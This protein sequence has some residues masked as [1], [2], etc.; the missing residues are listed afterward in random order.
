MSYLKQ[1]VVSL[2]DLTSLNND[3]TRTEIDVLISKSLNALGAVVAI[4]IY[5]EFISYAKAKIKNKGDNI[6]LA[7]VVNFPDAKEDLV[8]CI[9]LTEKALSGG[10]DEIDVVIPYHDYL[11]TG[12]S[13][14]A[15]ML[16]REL[17][18]LCVNKTL[19]VIIESGELKDASLIE[20]ASFDA[21]E[22]GADFIK[23]ST[24]KTPVGATLKAAEVMLNTIKTF[25]QNNPQSVVGFKASGGIRTYNDAC[26]Y[27]DL[28][29]K[30][31]GRDFIS[32]ATFRFGV[33]GL[34]DNLLA[35][36][37]STLSGY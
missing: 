16:V 22:N 36:K 4:C 10:A 1:E 3:D 11:K 27:L 18:A 35:D 29:E 32:P 21:F 5:P 15:G 23:T 12:S 28:A 6:R 26:Q 19:K 20:K 2:I 13:E 9:Y 24:G 30:I 14:H 8:R 25:S 37:A 34:L 33:S 7:T 17:K 31:C